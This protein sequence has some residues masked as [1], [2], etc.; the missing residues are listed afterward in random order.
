[1]IWFGTLAVVT[2]AVLRIS[3]PA[4]ARAPGAEPVVPI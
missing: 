4:A 2:V 3:P 1:L